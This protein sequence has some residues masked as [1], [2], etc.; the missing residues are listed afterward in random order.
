MD[1]RKYI[2]RDVNCFVLVSFDSEFMIKG[3]RVLISVLGF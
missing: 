3:I 1:L 2:L